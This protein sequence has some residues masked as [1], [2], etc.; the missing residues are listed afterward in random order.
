MALLHAKRAV[1][2]G[3]HL[4]IVIAQGAPQVFLVVGAAQRRGHHVFGDLQA[5]AVVDRVVKQQVVRAGFSKHR[6]ALGARGHD[7]LERLVA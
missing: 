1:V 2:G 3:D 5:V 7:V 6:D 4:Q